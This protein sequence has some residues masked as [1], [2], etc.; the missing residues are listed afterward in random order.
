M[1]TRGTVYITGIHNDGNLHTHQELERKVGAKMFREDLENIVT[2]LATMG[3]K[4]YIVTEDPELLADPRD[5]S[6]RP[7][8]KTKANDAFPRLTKADVLQRQKIYRDI[9]A[10]IKDATVIDT[11]D[12]WCPK[13]ECFAFTKDG[14]PTRFD[15][16]H[17]SF[18]GSEMLAN[19]VLKP[20]LLEKVQ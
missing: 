3:K 2:T 17:L 18:I 7:F 1:I 14:L 15:D 5:Y 4:V 11:V 20:Y 13:G 19:D 8:R 16:D 9:L 12:Y 6:S 10:N